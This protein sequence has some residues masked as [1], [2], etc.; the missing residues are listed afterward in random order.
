MNLIAQTI[1]GNKTFYSQLGLEY[2][3]KIRTKQFLQTLSDAIDDFV[4]IGNHREGTDK[5]LKPLAIGL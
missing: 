4:W 5:L 2:N 1:G 3:N